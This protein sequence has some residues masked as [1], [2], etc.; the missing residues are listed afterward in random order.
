MLNYSTSVVI[1]AAGKGTRMH[2]NIPKALHLL[3]GKPMIQYVINTAKE[4]NV[5]N[6]Y[7][8]YGHQGEILKKILKDEKLNWILQADQLGTGHAIQQVAPFL[9]DHEDIL[10]LYGDVPLISTDT[11]RRLQLEK[12]DKGI[13]LL[14]MYLEEPFGYGRII[15][16]NGEIVGIIEQKNATKEQ[17]EI[18]EINTGILLIGGRDLKRWLNA[19]INH[20]AEKKSEYYI[21]D[22]I[23]LASKQNCPI[24]AVHPYES[25]EARGV[26]N[27][28]ELAQLERFYQIKQAKNLLLS[29]VTLYD[30]TRFDMRGRLEYGCDVIIDINVIIEGNVV[31]GNRV[32]IGIGCFIKNSIISDDSI[33]YSYSVI[34]DSY[35]GPRC[36]VGPFAHLRP[37]SKLE[38]NSQVGNFVEIKNSYVG[39]GSKV[40]H[41]SYVGDAKIGENVNIGAGTVTCNY[42]GV[43]K[44]Q[45]IIGDDVFIGSGTYLVAPVRVSSGVTIAAGTT[46]LRDIPSI[47]LVYNEKK[48][49]I[50]NNWNRKK[51]NKESEV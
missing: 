45:T 34:E 28:F 49:I 15:R 2:S 13:A 3:A 30:I 50:H 24:V 40:G 48:Q 47:G 25:I 43:K 29:G 42:D 9:N 46:I 8:V 10:I 41:L 44:H 27:H 4:L 6:I 18:K 37:N 11:L 17:L 12:I 31:I 33:I 35:L 39:E 7:L 51:K 23:A 22:I 20:Q 19:I 1:L 21:T 5:K 36:R 26:N 32:K 14:T 38:E 16:K